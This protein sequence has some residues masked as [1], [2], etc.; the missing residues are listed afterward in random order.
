M[1]SAAGPG[2][3]AYLPSFNPINPCHPRDLRGRRQVSDY[4]VLEHRWKARDSYSNHL[5]HAL[6][7][8]RRHGRLHSKGIARMALETAAWSFRQYEGAEWRK[9]VAQRRSA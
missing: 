4:E 1:L 7:A 9:I 6:S 8:A 5:R 3:G 2:V